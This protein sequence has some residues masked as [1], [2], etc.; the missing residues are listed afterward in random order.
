VL[1][2]QLTDLHIVEEGQLLL[3]RVDTAGFLRAAVDAVMAL[4]PRAEAVILTGDL[5]NDGLLAQYLHLRELLSPLQM[6]VFLLPGNHDERGALR[7]A[8]PDHAELGSVGTC[9]YVVDVGA[10]RLIALD[11]LVDG[12]GGGALSG[13]QLE[14]LDARLG[15]APERPTLVAVH[16]PPFLTAI[17]YM[18]AMGL[19][20]ESVDAFAA[21]IARHPHVER[22][23]CGHLHRTISRRWAG[24]VAAT[25]PSAC[26]AV[27]MLLGPGAPAGVTFEP[28]AMT[29]HWWSEQTGL[30][31]H[32]QAIG[33]FELLGL[34]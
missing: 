11:S 19:Q 23:T 27:A 7:A 28:P 31:T 20:Q 14:W 5:V 9:D 16:H 25:T 30:V 32:Q 6:P 3:G 4:R 2:V 8:F 18:D 24:T 21:V 34:A 26:H 17:E 22:V 12:Q 15:E 29:V 1:L 33:D 10:L 13:Q